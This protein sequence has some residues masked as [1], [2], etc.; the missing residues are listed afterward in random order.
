MIKKNWLKWKLIGY[1]SLAVV[2]LIARVVLPTSHW[3]RWAVDHF[4]IILFVPIPIVFLICVLLREWKAL[5]ILAIPVLAFLFLYGRLLIPSKQAEHRAD[6]ISLRAMTFNVLYTNSDQAAV[7]QVIKDSGADFVGLQEL[8]PPNATSLNELLSDEFPFHTPLPDGHYPEVALYS[9]YPILEAEQL[10]LPLGDRSWMT[11]VD[12]GGVRIK[13]IVLHLVPTRTGE[14]PMSQWT[15]RITERQVVRR[16]QVD[17]VIEAVR[18]G[19]EP[20]L[21]LC[22]CNFTEFSDAYAI[23]DGFLDDSFALSGWGLGHT[24]DPLNIDLRLQRIDYVWYSSGFSPISAQII[25][26]RKSD[27]NPLVVELDLSLEDK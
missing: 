25:T 18:E 21:V 3:I 17:R 16:E 26:E 10:N 8:T 5:I 15:Q 24:T 22:D 1:L 6:A 11:I 23:L 2:V 20:A 27:H 14:V 4:L 7:A 13:V 19:Q 9:R 12:L